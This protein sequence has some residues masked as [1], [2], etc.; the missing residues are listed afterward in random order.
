M[1]I[2]EF[3]ENRHQNWMRV[4]DEWNSHTGDGAVDQCQQMRDHLNEMYTVFGM[5]SLLCTIKVFPGRVDILETFVRE[6]V[7]KNMKEMKALLIKTKGQ[8][9]NHGN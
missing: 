8:D 5:L 9:G 2:E 6:Q 7:D 1:D 4:I 3:Y